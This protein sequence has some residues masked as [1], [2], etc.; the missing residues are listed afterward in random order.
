MH[1]NEHCITEDTDE[2]FHC[3]NENCSCDPCTCTKAECCP[4]EAEYQAF[5]AKPFGADKYP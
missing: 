1:T 3:A 5:V 4:D 2:E